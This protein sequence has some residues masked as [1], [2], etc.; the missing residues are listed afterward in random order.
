MA[1]VAIGREAIAREQARML[2]ANPEALA[3]YEIGTMDVPAD[4]AAALEPMLGRSRRGYHSADDVT[5]LRGD[6]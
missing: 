6:G 4:V 2:A 1:D 3:A 5:L